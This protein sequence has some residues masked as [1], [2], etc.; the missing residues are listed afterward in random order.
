MTSIKTFRYRM[1]PTQ[2]QQVL[3]AKHFGSKRFVYNYF[4]NERKSE[5]GLK[6]YSGLGTKSESK[7]KC[8]EAFS[9]EKSM[10]HEAQPLK[11]G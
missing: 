6:I 1:Y 10:S 3:L 4:L 8:E 9:S 7:Q 5:Q 2:E 11:G